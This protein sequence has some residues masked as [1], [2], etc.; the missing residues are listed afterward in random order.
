MFGLIYTTDSIRDNRNNFYHKRYSE[1]VPSIFREVNRKLLIYCYHLLSLIKKR[2][3]H[4]KKC[5]QNL[6][7]ND[8]DL[9]KMMERFEDLFNLGILWECLE[10]FSIKHWFKVIILLMIHCVITC[11]GGDTYYSCL[12]LHLNAWTLYRW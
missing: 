3:V 7:S 12:V 10:L 5:L 9:K 6:R 8:K 11:S 4:T 1:K 2:G